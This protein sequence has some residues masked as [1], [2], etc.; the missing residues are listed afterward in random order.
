[1]K[2]FSKVNFLQGNGLMQRRYNFETGQFDF[3]SFLLFN[4][5]ITLLVK[6]TFPLKLLVSLFWERKDVTQLYIGNVYK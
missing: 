2:Q 1:M 6:I 5:Y 4:S 3:S